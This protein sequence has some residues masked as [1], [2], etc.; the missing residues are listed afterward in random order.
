MNT[1]SGIIL[2][3]LLLS[4]SCSKENLNLTTN[5]SDS[6]RMKSFGTDIL[7]LEY[8]IGR[9]PSLEEVYVYSVESERR[10]WLHRIRSSTFI[11]DEL[12]KEEYLKQ[13][14]LD[15]IYIGEGKTLTEDPIPIIVENLE[16]LPQSNNRILVFMSN[17]NII[18]APK[19]QFKDLIGALDNTLE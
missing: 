18:R 15:F 2:T 16:T 7:T 5:Y 11:T 19:S 17:G 12:S 8:E 10:L 13:K 4:I 9:M 6:N 1:N 3:L 14:K